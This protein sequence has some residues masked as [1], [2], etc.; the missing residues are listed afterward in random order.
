MAVTRFHGVTTLSGGEYDELEINGVIT[1]N[2]DMKG[3][4]I[5]VDGVV[6]IN[7]KL[8]A[9]E[10]IRLNGVDTL[11]QSLRAKD[12]SIDGVC[13]IG[14]NVEADH[15]LC[16]GVLTCKGQISADLI[17]GNGALSIKEMV[18]EKVIIRCKGKKHGWFAKK[19]EL[20]KINTI[21]AT[22]IDVDGI[23]CQNLNGENVTIGPNCVIENV[24]CTGNLSIAPEAEVSRVNGAER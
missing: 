15:V 9:E 10:S 1:G 20:S 23:Q 13:T 16:K 24:E 11:N 12:I 22:E 3:R 19:R 18:G 6:T 14:G 2:G 5:S 8:E 7:G 21:E 4:T 17:E